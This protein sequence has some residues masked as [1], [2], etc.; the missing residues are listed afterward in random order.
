MNENFKKVESM[1][2]DENNLAQEEGKNFFGDP[3]LNLNKV[4]ADV[5]TPG[6]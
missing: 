2:S 6:T 1:Y 4:I 5:L 3:N